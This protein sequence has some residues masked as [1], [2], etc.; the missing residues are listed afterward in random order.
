MVTF[1]TYEPVVPLLIHGGPIRS[2]DELGSMPEALLVAD[3]R[4]MKHGS[5][6]ELEVHLGSNGLKIDTKGA[7]VIP[8]LIDTHPHLLHFAARSESFV[9][10]S[11][12]VDHDDIVRRIAA[13]AAMTPAGQWIMATPVGEPFYFIRRSYRDLRERV[14]PNC[15]VLDRATDRHPVF[16]QAWTPRT[17]NVCAF[18]SLALKALA[19]TD[20]IPDRVADVWIDKDEDG[21]LTGLLYGSVNTMYCFDPFWTQVYSKIPQPSINPLRTTKTAMA[22]YNR[23]GVTTVY[24]AHNMSAEH[25]GVYRA[26]RESR[27]LTVRVMAAMEVELY[28]A[29]PYQPKTMEQFREALGTARSL[30]IQGDDYLCVRG[31]TLSDTAPCWTGYMRSFEPYRDPY[32]NPTKGVRFISPDKKRAFVRYCIEHH[33]RANFCS[34]APGD[35]EELLDILETAEGTGSEGVGSVSKGNWII[36]HA[37]HITPQQTA[38]FHRLGFDVTAS[39]GLSWGLGDIDTK[40]NGPHIRRDLVPLNRFLEQGITVAAGSDWGPKNAFEQIKLAET[41]EFAGSGY[42][43]DGPDQKVTREQAFAM[44]TREAAKVLR[45]PHMGSLAIGNHADIVIVDRDPLSCGIDDL[46]DTEVLRT[47][48][49]GHTVFDA[50]KL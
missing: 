41:H 16:I 6:R 38:R 40:R 21:R 49:G 10:L 5:V 20:H 29:P 23:L 25:I 14:L 22:E 7:T 34:G 3:G 8:G 2:M 48:L 26:L 31:V 28:A 11:D 33:M 17:P 15:D 1:P 43:N 24:E 12:A 45:W 19:L 13:K 42:R 35:H 37:F 50:G 36:Q 32:G 4:I 44:W 30:Q 47:I 39:V 9:D 46:P 18:N 27:E